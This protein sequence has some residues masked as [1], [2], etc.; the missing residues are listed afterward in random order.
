M[1]PFAPARHTASMSFGP[2][3]TGEGAH[4]HLWAPKQKKVLLKL[5]EPMQMHPMHAEQDG[6]H[7][8]HVPNVQPGARYRFVLSDG[9]EV[10]D[11][12]SRFQPEDVHG[13]SELID[14]GTYTWKNSDWLGR[15]WEELVIYALHVGAFTRKGR[16]VLRWS[17]STTCAALG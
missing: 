7:H 5:E 2:E 10:P 11:P 8:L 4:F 15:P 1:I 9:Q 12:A 17:A 6:W 16:S 14:P 3:L 13:P